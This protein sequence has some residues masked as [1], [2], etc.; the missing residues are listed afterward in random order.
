[1]QELAGPWTV[2]FDPKWGGPAT[3]QFDSLISW[4]T[5]SEPG[6]KYYSGTATYEHTLETPA[7]L[8]G[9]ELWLDLGEVH[10]LAEVKVNGVSCG[11]VWCPPFRVNISRAVQ[12]GQNQLSVEVVN[13]WPNRIIGDASQPV[14]K[15][16]TRTNIRN[17]TAN[18]PLEPA[19]LLGPVQLLKSAAP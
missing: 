2:H 14:E 11:I 10:E 16:L 7:H 18:T 19:G 8:G 13:F 1:M 6:I 3:T 4:P 17:L 15:R 5:S 9:A 12:P